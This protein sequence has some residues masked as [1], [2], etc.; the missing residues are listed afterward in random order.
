LYSLV[1]FQKDIADD[2]SFSPGECEVS[3]LRHTEILCHLHLSPV[4]VLTSYFHGEKYVGAEV[5]ATVVMSGSTD[6]PFHCE[7]KNQVMPYHTS[8]QQ[9]DRQCFQL[10]LKRKINFGLEADTKKLPRNSKFES[11]SNTEVTH[12][13]R[14]HVS[15][16]TTPA[17]KF[18]TKVKSKQLPQ[19][20]SNESK[21]KEEFRSRKQQ[22]NAKVLPESFFFLKSINLFQICSSSAP[23]SA[24]P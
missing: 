14:N 7:L 16:A 17:Q 21:R 12:M 4:F 11:N 24:T 1:V 22:D 15:K 13:E 8:L 10:E 5:L 6:D 3:I 20:R 9:L 19:Q 18:S 2:D 23:I